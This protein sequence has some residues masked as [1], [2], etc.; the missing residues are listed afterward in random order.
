MHEIS[1]LH[2][3]T[4]ADLPYRFD[5]LDA[6]LDAAGLDA[7]VATSKHNV[8]YLLGG[9]QFIFFS[10]MDAIGQ[11]RYLPAFVY[12][13]GNPDATGY[14][15]N[16]MEIH[17][18]KVAPFWVPEFR[19]DHWGSVDTMQAAAAHLQKCG[20]ASGRI[21]FEAGF[22][23]KDGYDALAEALPQAS[24]LDAS[25]VLTRLR[26]IKTKP[27][28]DLLREATARISE[29]MQATILGSGAGSSK[30]QIIER[31]RQEE[32]KRELTFE[33]CLLT[34]GDSHVRAGSGQTWNAGEVMSIDSGG[35]LHGYIGDIC[36]MGVLGEPDQE[37][38]D[39]LAEVEAVQQAAFARIGPGET[40][41]AMIAAAEAELRRGP[42]AAHNDF[43]AHGMGLISH[44]APFLM[45]NHPVAYEG[46]DAERP[47]APGM[48]LSVETTLQ[49][50]RRGYIKLE[51]TV[52]VT[53]EGHE[54]FGADNR[55]WIVS[56]PD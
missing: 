2:A 29:A 20:V 28:L 37:L 14:F 19:P 51:D 25:M 3:A 27:E 38:V 35:N 17:E 50:P 7:L 24:L 46:V 48:V 55:G 13:R 9:Y 32:S 4:P 21:G 15:A 49:H 22:M 54:L 6:A 52:I 16:K 8:R 40:G 1:P 5:E 31:L 39:I 18:H 12:V 45:T 41:A 34:L 36:R 23:P 11:S 33:Y 26:M 10:A 30:Y 44:E 53:A 43:F 56:S 42:N 47:F